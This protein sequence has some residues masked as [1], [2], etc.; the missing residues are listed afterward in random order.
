MCL[1]LASLE[2]RSQDKGLKPIRE[3]KPKGHCEGQGRDAREEEGAHTRMCHLVHW[4]SVQLTVQPHSSA[5][6]EVVSQASQS[7]GRKG[8]FAYQPSYLIKIS[9][10]GEPI[11]NAS[12][13]NMTHQNPVDPMTC[14]AHLSERSPRESPGKANTG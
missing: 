7:R 5:F 12:G 14:H 6:W 9:P 13:L 10:Q 2:G 8:D 11:P 1:N 3:C 4:G